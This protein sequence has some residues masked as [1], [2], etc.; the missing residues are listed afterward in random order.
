MLF[1]AVNRE[2]A[3]DCCVGEKKKEKCLVVRVIVD[4][5]VW[6]LERAGASVEGSVEE[7]NWMDVCGEKDWVL[8]GLCLGD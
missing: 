4:I 7:R 1:Y 2:W 6:Y 3:C 8:G 5:A